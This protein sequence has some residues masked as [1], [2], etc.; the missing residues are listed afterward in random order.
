MKFKCKHCGW[1]HENADGY[2]W[3]TTDDQIVFDHEKN[4]CPVQI[5]EDYTGEYK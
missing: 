1:T 2:H 3:Q 5:R 4:S